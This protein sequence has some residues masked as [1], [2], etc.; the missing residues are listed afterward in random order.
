VINPISAQLG[1]LWYLKCSG[2]RLV[3]EGFIPSRNV[4]CD[5]SIPGFPVMLQY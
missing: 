4:H 3:G 1:F 5:P 2:V